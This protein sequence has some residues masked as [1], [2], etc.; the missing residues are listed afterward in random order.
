M[1]PGVDATT[2]ATIIQQRAGPDGVDGTDDDTPF[3]DVGQVASAW[4]SARRQNARAAYAPRAAPHLKSISLRRSAIPTREFVAI[5]FRNSGHGHPGRWFLLEVTAQIGV[6]FAATKV[7]VPPCAGFLMILLLLGS[8]SAA[9]ASDAVTGRV[10][11]VLPLLLDLKGS[12]RAFRRAFTTATLIRFIC[13]STRTKFPPSVST[14]CGRRR[15]P[16]TQN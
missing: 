8:L 10:V 13:A 9:S 11:K 16:A 6:E 4:I 14:S 7:I 2:A 5:F 15:T 12:R 1:I 3:R